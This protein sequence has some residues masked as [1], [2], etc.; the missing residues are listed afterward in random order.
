MHVIALR[1]G[2]AA[3]RLLVGKN[4]FHIFRN[5]VI[6][7]LGGEKHLS[8]SSDGE[9][10]RKIRDCARQRGST[11]VTMHYLSP[12]LRK[13]LGSAI[14]H[15][16]CERERKSLGVPDAR[17]FCSVKK[18]KAKKNV[19]NKYRG[20][21]DREPRRVSTFSR[22]KI[23]EF[24][25]SF[26]SGWYCSCERLLPAWHYHLSGNETGALYFWIIIT[27]QYRVCLARISLS[28]EL[29]VTAGRGRL[30][31]WWLIVTKFVVV[32]HRGPM[33]VDDNYK[34]VRRTRSNQSHVEKNSARI[35]LMLGTVF[36]LRCS[37]LL[38]LIK[39]MKTRNEFFI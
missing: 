38:S 24:D 19:R 32:A 14:K 31:V 6:S 39:I 20:R 3:C 12:S 2:L 23:F 21:S 34:A 16:I 15:Y 8:F 33:P 30:C 9:L 25:R 4:F 7:R 28:L 5:I 13:L 22:Q 27:S 10:R 26:S 35:T 11:R 18:R 29:R 36:I 37:W 1:L 17:S